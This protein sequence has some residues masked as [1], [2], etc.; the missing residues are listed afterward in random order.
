MYLKHPSLIGET[1]G[2][3]DAVGGGAVSGRFCEDG[4]FDVVG[5]ASVILGPVGGVSGVMES[6]VPLQPDNTRKT[7]V[8]A[9]TFILMGETVPEHE[10][11]AGCLLLRFEHTETTRKRREGARGEPCGEAGFRGRTRSGGGIQIGEQTRQRRG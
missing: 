4:G 5:A 9:Q 1:A 6:P 3:P 10:G 11:C 2:E 7:A 8:D